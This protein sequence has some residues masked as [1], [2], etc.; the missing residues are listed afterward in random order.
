M[1]VVVEGPSAAGKTTWCRQHAAGFVAEHVPTGHAPEDTDLQAQAA[2]WT[3]VNVGRW[4]AAVR[5]EAETG[6]AVCD[7]DPLKLHYS[8]SLARVGAV[9]AE[10]FERELLEVRYAFERGELGLPDLALVTLPGQ[11]ELQQR[12]DGDPSRRRRHFD[13]HR[14]LAD[15]LREWYSAM[16]QLDPERVVWALPDDGLAGCPAVRPRP[17]RTDVGLLDRLMAGLPALRHG[18]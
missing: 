15:P 14:R 4:T 16:A 1:I 10:R 5:L 3:A 2:S 8:W 12:K 7:S 11:E 17:S 9:P 6:T 18:G 13:L